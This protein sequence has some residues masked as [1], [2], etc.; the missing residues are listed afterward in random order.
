MVMPTNRSE[1]R[2]E[3]STQPVSSRLSVSPESIHELR[4]RTQD[5]GRQTRQP[6]A[7]PFATVLSTTAGAPASG[8]QQQPAVE[9]RPRRSALGLRH[10]DEASLYGTGRR[11]RVILKG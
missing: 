4:T 3:G 6:A 8:A 11:A 2:I 9:Q 1:R 10:P 5:H 7:T